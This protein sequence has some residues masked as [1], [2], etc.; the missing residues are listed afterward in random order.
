MKK[1]KKI[2]IVPRNDLE[3]VEIINLLS[4]SGEKVV[5]SQQRWGARWENLEPEVVSEVETLLAQNPNV[6][7]VGVEIAG[8]PRWDGRNIDH[9][10]WSDSD[11]SHESSSLE[12][13][14]DLLGVTLSRYLRQVAENDKGWIPALV[15]AGATAGEIGYIRLTDRCSQ[16]VTPDDEAEAVR[17]I[18]LAVWVGKRVI[19]TTTLS[20][21]Q[22]SPI[23]D[24]V[25]GQADEWLVKAANAW[26]YNGPRHTEL[27]GWVKSSSLGSDRDW[28]GGSPAF[29]YAGFVNPSKEL[30][31]KI[32]K[33]FVEG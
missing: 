19:V 11:R 23:S 15:K 20:S 6:E 1:N 8:A 18:A 14:A 16:G 24:R 12:Q 33:F 10:R 29:G 4:H 5:V 13:V 22:L 9:H 30:Q 31:S 25:Y 7:V 2:F 17:A 26:L 21:F 28:S 32:E 3:A 27:F